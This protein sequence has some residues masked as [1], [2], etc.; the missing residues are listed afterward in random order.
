MQLFFVARSAE[1]RARERAR[2]M[3]REREKE[4]E[5]REKNIIMRHTNERNKWRE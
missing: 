5:R 2:E 4:T 1:R 3:Q